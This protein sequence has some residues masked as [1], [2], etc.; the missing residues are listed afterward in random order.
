MAEL[1]TGCPHCDE[2]RTGFH[3]HSELNLDHPESV[4]EDDWAT[5]GRR[6]NNFLEVPVVSL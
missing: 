4:T 2:P 1:A 3:L 5:W 6:K